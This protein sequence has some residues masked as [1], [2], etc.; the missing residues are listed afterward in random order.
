MP[1][2]VFFCQSDFKMSA[3]LP[4]YR[5][6]EKARRNLAKTVDL[7]LTELQWQEVMEYVAVQPGVTQ[8]FYKDI[9]LWYMREWNLIPGVFV[10]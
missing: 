2:H 9:A 8:S 7:R 6:A 1:I 5:L 4:K 3:G 10:L